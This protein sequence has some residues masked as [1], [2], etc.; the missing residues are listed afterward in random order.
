MRRAVELAQAQLGRTSPNPTVGCVIVREGVI[1]AEAATG[2]GGRP[3]AEEA[4]L[5]LLNG[6]ARGA[7][8]YVTLEPC[9]ERSTG[10]HS[11][12][13]LLAEAGVARV[14]FA[15]DDPSPYAS[16]IG[17]EHLRAAGVTVESGL[18]KDEAFG[19]IHGF[20][21]YLNTGRPLVSESLDGEGYDAR[22]E[23]APLSDPSEDLKLWGGRG[24]RRLWVET[25]SDLAQHLARAG[26]LH[27]L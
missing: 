3:H 9:G 13:R 27:S 11:C 7:V 26:L 18:L 23:P 25:G 2:D 12:S 5:S 21:H 22:Y 15:C 16:T 4:A 19:L 8:A 17:I 10:G 24:F 20:V 1:L 6:E 14:V